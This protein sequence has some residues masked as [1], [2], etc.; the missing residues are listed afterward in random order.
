ML[1]LTLD[2]KP[3]PGN[4]MEGQVGA[5][6]VD[7]IDPPKDTAKT[8]IAALRPVGYDIFNLGSDEPLK[9]ID[10]IGKRDGVAAE[11]HWFRHMD[12]THKLFVSGFEALTI[13]DLMEG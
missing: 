1:R 11:A 4:P 6:S 10:L 9:L 3:A 5:S 8:A 12:I 13:H 7:V 2:G